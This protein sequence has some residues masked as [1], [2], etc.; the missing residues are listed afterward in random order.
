MPK[1]KGESIIY[2]YIATIY[3]KIRK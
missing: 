2:T 1:V 3:D